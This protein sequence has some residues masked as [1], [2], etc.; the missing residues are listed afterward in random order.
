MQELKLGLSGLRGRF[1]LLV[2]VIF[3]LVG[4]LT[5]FGFYRFTER[6]VL[7]LGGGY[8]TQY[9][10]RQQARIAAKLEREVVLAEKLVDSPL[11]KAWAKNEHDLALRHQAMQELDSFRRLFDDRSYF[12]IIDASKNYYFNNAQD[13]FR[14]RELRY[15]VKRDDPI[16]NWYFDTIQKVDSFALH[17][18]NSP[19]LG[20]TK[21][22]INAV[23]KDKEQK[24]GLGGS[25]LDLTSF[26]KEIVQSSEPG[27]ETVL[28]DTQ[29]R[30]Q[31]HSDSHLMK[32]NVVIKDESKRLK[33]YDLV[34]ASQH[35][36]LAHKISALAAT[37][38]GIDH[39]EIVRAGHK[40]IIGA[41]AMPEIGWIALVFVDPTQV[42]ELSQFLPILAVLGIAL[43]VSLL[44][45]S[46]AIDRLILR[47]LSKLTA[48]TF[49]IAA[50]KYS[51]DLKVDSRDEL[52]QLTRS[53]NHMTATVRDYT[54]NLEQKVEERTEEL[55][56]SNEKLMDS[57]H[58]ARLIQSALLAKPAELQATFA[59]S[60][61]YWRPRDVVGGDFY[62]LYTAPNKGFL[63]AVVDCTGHGVPGAFM[64][65]ASKA[66]LDRAVAALGL[67]DPASLL[68]ELHR[69]LRELL[70]QEEPGSQNGLD[71][72]VLH[73]SPEHKLIRYAGARIPLWIQKPGQPIE[74]LK[75]DR[76]SL[77]YSKTEG[78]LQLTNHDLHLPSGTRLYLVSDGILDQPGGAKGF[79]LGPK[80]LQ[81]A[82]LRWENVPLNAM[83]DLLDQLLDEYSSGATQRD[84]ITVI[85]VAL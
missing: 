36:I 41:A 23:V 27:V 60:F 61:T 8:A 31:G 11:L 74:V 67:S 40:V 51:V 26:L 79:G 21:V 62:T 69:T 75:A 30:I 64:S 4:A 34:E 35:D 73:G 9:A 52:G 59:D 13:E 25:G 44:L 70:Q 10:Q 82:F 19:Q 81:E 48:S 16:S 22:W 1:L 18:D 47:R 6:V 54:H 24:L 3:T 63:L 50:G 49:E 37:P 28:I 15:V 53:F 55:R 84:D 32:Q 68:Q 80:P 43:L 12:F 38:G 66:L 71:V 33:I 83:N 46:Y 14:G 7:G 45:I 42:I 20:L 85:G 17:V 72:A 77:G 78:E 57:I 76:C 2:L 58:Y 39:F 5:V 29:G 65:M 56:L